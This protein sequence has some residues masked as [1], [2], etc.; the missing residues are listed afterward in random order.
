[1]RY[2]EFNETANRRPRYTKYEISK[3][4]NEKLINSKLTK[5]EFCIKFDIDE[6]TLNDILEANRS[7]NKMLL[8]K[9]STLVEIVVKVFLLVDTLP[10]F[11]SKEIKDDTIETFNIANLLF[12]E[13]IMQ[14][15]IS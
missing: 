15:K 5:S 3:R 7:F 9:S 11:R 4:V 1:M 6:K 8:K 13:I 14:N 2:K 12:N 10:A